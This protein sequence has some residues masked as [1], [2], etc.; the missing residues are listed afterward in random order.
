VRTLHPAATAASTPRS[1]RPGP[2]SSATA[3]K[4]SRRVSAC[5]KAASIIHVRGHQIDGATP[6]RVPPPCVQSQY[7]AGIDAI[8]VATQVKACAC[9]ATNQPKAPLRATR[10]YRQCSGVVGGKSLGLLL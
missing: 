4:A 8:T 10:T 3:D 5:A 7:D 9:S 6:P 1:T 2:R